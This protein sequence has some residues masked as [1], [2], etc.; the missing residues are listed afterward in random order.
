MRL[1]LIDNHSRLIFGDTA[2]YRL[3]GLDEWRDSNSDNSSVIERL[4]LLAA[5]LLVA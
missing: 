5:R 4:S 2:N 1:I 3:G